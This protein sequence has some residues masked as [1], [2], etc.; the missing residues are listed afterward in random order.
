MTENEF[1]L[2]DRLAKIQSVINKYGEENFYISFSGGKDS[3]VLSALIDM[4]LPDNKIPR[5]YANTGIEYR[6]IV[7]FVEK[8]RVK[9]HPWELVILKPENNIMQT[10]REYGYPFKSKQH[11]KWVDMF[12]RNGHTQSIENYISGENR[13]KDLYRVCPKKLL[14]QFR[15]D[16]DIRISDKCCFYM[17]EKPLDEWAKLHHKP[18]GIHGIMRAEG[19]QT[20]EGTMFGFSW[21]QIKGFSALIARHK[22][23]GRMVY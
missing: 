1:I 20:Y 6:L 7:D 23:M 4:A 16:F 22:G 17:K 19:G 5:I 8:E 10:L 9:P 11:A 14:Y 21:G 13:D 3:T 15:G 2:Q 12:Q 18:Y